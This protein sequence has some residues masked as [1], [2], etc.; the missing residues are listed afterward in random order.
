MGILLECGK[1]PASRGVMPSSGIV[2]V[3]FP[4]RPKLAMASQENTLPG[5]VMPPLGPRG[6]NSLQ[7]LLC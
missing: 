2:L 6:W 3:D 5:S 4:F 1:Q 7:N